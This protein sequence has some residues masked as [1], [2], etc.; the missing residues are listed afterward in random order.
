MR[1]MAVAGPEGKPKP[2]VTFRCVISFQGLFGLKDHWKLH[3]PGG[4]L[5]ARLQ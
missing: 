4:R 3:A 5:D 2:P 1:H